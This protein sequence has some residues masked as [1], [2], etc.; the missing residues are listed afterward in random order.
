MVY[1]ERTHW[2]AADLAALPDDGYHY[3]LVKG[4]LVQMPPRDRR[5]WRGQQ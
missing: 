1:T 2:T 4:R 3:E 5:P